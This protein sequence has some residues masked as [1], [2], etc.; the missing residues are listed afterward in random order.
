LKGFEEPM[1][2]RAGVKS[3]AFEP[4]LAAPFRYLRVLFG[5]F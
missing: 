2:P 3:R 1:S 5:F 4:F